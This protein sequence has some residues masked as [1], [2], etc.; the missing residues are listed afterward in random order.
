MLRWLRLIPKL[1][2]QSL[3]S[4]LKASNHKVVHVPARQ[5]LPHPKPEHPPLQ[6]LHPKPRWPMN[7]L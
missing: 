1:I 6:P 4:A 5:R 7:W 3:L 2:L